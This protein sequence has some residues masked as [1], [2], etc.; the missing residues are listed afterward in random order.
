VGSRNKV[1]TYGI[2][3]TSSKEQTQARLLKIYQHVNELLDKH[4]PQIVAMEQLFVSTGDRSAMSVLG[5]GQAV[6][7]ISLAC[8]LRGLEVHDYDAR[9]IKE[10]VVGYGAA[11]KEQ[12]QF[13][14]Q[15]LLGLQEKPKP[16]HA[17]DALAVAICHAHTAGSPGRR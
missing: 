4:Q 10:A 9:R 17:A 11:T 14:V 2:I 8:A 7:V 6:G 5:V 12:I 16:D 1:I 13:M 3:T 15:R